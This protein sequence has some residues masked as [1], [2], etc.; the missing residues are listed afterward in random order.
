MHSPTT[1]ESTKIDVYLH[2]DPIEKLQKSLIQPQTE[3]APAAAMDSYDII[4]EKMWAAP[5]LESPADWPKWKAYVEEMIKL[6]GVWE[7]CDPSIRRCDL[8]K[9]KEPVK[10][11]ITSVKPSITS[12]VDLEPD[13][14]AKLASLVSK[15]KAEK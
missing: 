5:L 11:E 7:Y 15:Y 2:N 1:Q 4:T 12:I 3:K 8:P 6:C 13:D 9:L 10:P 14:F